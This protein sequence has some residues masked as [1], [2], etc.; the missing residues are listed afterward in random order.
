MSYGQPRESG[1][2]VTTTGI[3][4]AR[5]IGEALS[6]AYKGD[7]TIQYADG[8]QSIRVYWQR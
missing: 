1:A 5:R 6:R 4:Q 2:S 3:H 7:L 8:E